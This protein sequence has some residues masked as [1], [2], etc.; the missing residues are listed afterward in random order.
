MAGSSSGMP[1][2]AILYRQRLR[3]SCTHRPP[4][5]LLFSTL[6]IH[7]SEWAPGNASIRQHA[8]AA[9]QAVIWMKSQWNISSQH[10]LHCLMRSHLG[11][12]A[13]EELEAHCSNLQLLVAVQQQQL[14]QA[15]TT[16]TPAVSVNP[17]ACC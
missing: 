2:A 10:M 9:A 7:G 15:C 5:R 8:N 16:R 13:L 17:C 11:V 12:L 3:L 14:A 1:S 6:H 4:K